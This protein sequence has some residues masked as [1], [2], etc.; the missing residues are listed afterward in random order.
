MQHVIDYFYTHASPWAYL[1]HQTFLALADAHDYAVRFR[2]VLLGPVFSETG[3]LPL[4]KRHPVRQA[5][6]QVELQRWRAK[7]ELPL[8]PRPAHFPTNPALADRIALGLAMDGGPTGAFSQ[9]V[10][11]ALW[12]EDRDIAREEVL[13]AILERLGVDADKAIDH[14]NEKD[15]VARYEQNQEDAVMLGV[16]G[17]P[18]YVLHGEVFWGQDRLDLLDDALTSGRGPYLPD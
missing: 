16:F 15:C 18:S 10:F 13:R 12:A 1:G 3:G 8:T 4:A 11:E 5:Y 9:A 14:A 6:R 2:P 17:S 7:R